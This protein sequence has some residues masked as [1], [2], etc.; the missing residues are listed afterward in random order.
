[1]KDK[2]LFE[3]TVPYEFRRTMK[4]MELK[5]FPQKLIYSY[6]FGKE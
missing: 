6:E 1:M 2:E 5:N 4:D 3:I